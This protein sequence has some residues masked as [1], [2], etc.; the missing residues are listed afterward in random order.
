M[1]AFGVGSA[2]MSPEPHGRPAKPRFNHS[3][4]TSVHTLAPSCFSILMKPFSSGV[5]AAVVAPV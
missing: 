2:Q 1:I 4:V 5:P 3:S